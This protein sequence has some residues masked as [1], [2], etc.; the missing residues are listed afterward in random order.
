MR[1]RQTDA[2]GYFGTFCEAEIFSDL[3]SVANNLLA[4]SSWIFIALN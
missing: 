3:N 1:G 4:T 2:E